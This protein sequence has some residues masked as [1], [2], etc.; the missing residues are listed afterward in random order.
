[1]DIA[2]LTAFAEIVDTGSFSQAAQNLHLT[3]PAISKR[4]AKL[5]QALGT[6]LLDRIGRHIKPTEAGT[7]LLGHSKKIFADISQAERAIRE[8][9]S[10]VSGNLHIATSH[11]IGL[12][13]LPPILKTFSD[14]YPS[15]KMQIEF[16]DSE[17]AHTLVS[18]G[19]VEL[20]I[21]TLALEENNQLKS[22]ELWPDPLIVMAAT[23]HPL[24][25]V[26]NLSL[27]ELAKYPCVLPGLDTYTGQIVKNLFD[28]ASLVL[29]ASMATNYLETI[30]MLVS[31]GMGWTVLPKSMFDDRLIELKISKLS[32]SRQLGYITHKQH[33]LSTAATAFINLLIKVKN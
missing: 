23:T 4:I 31:V 30:K 18:D 11:H 10:E 9:S 6:P 32:L 20:A 22:T 29:D 26:K 25:T 7:E 24:A 17:K 1:M 5:E 3:Q 28:K 12:H 21:I 8:M 14:R 19:D 16:T 2:A 13:R 15:V 27:V 33:N